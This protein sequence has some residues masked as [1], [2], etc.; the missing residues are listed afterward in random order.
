MKKQQGFT[1]I[2]LMIVVAIIAILAAIALPAYQDYTI[3]SRV[4]EMAVLASGAKA[5]IGENIANEN[6]INANACRGVATFNTATTNTA[7]LACA[8]GT[9]TGTAKASNVV[10]TYAPSLVDA[11]IRWTCSSASAAKYLPA[12]CRGSGT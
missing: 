8:N 4:S 10:L 12:E 7:S 2:E 6:A 11:G 1:L 5:T 9:V 3:R